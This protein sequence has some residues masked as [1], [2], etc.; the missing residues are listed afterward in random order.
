MMTH[1]VVTCA[2]DTGQPEEQSSPQNAKISPSPALLAACTSRQ[3]SGAEPVVSELDESPELDSSPDVAASSPD[4]LDA[5][6][7]TGSSATPQAATN[8]RT[9]ERILKPE[10]ERAAAR[11]AGHAPR[12][13]A[14]RGD[15]GGDKEADEPDGAQV[16]DGA[17]LDNSAGRYCA[18]GTQ[19]PPAQARWG[20]LLAGP[21][22]G[23]FS[24]KIA[25]RAPGR[26]THARVP[27]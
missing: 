19:Q 11:T 8:K 10:R 7:L 21:G 20:L 14:L 6:E 2:G 5:E 15:E 17:I 18:P 3:T 26:R 23:W 13:Q 24:A 9:R 1:S 27:S 12:L 25:T 16:R 22:W 4:S